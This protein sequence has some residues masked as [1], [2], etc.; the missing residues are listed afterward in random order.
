MHPRSRYG[1]YLAYCAVTYIFH[2]NVTL[3]GLNIK[4]HLL[5]LFHTISCFDTISFIVCSCLRSN[6]IY[7]KKLRCDGIMDWEHVCRHSVAVWR[8]V[9][10]LLTVTDTK[11]TE[12]N[13]LQGNPVRF[14]LRIW[15]CVCVCMYVAKIARLNVYDLCF[16][17][18]YT[19]QDKLPRKQYYIK[20]AISN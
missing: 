1:I 15:I 14:S 16:A 6:T 12:A 17:A 20:Q 8:T 18:W 5:T 7:S 4:E 10:L 19:Q 13:F 2:M 11:T 3:S 9:T